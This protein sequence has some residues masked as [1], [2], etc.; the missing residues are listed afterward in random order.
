MVGEAGIY[1]YSIDGD[2]AFKCLA[3]SD[4][5]NGDYLVSYV[6]LDTYRGPRRVAAGR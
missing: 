4:V 5:G 2:G 6:K 1:D 3:A